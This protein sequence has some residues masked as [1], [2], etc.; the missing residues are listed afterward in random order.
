VSQALSPLDEPL[1][2]G[3]WQ[4]LP[5]PMISRYLA[6]MKW[7]WVVLD[8]QHGPMSFETA[9]ECVQ[10]L[11]AG[12]T[13]PLVRVAINTPFEVQ[14][15]LDIG[16]AGVVVP[17]TNTLDMAR[18]LAAAAKYPPR[19]ERSL[20]GDASLLQGEDYPERAN[21][22][23][24]LLVQ[25]EHAAAVAVVDGMMAI[26]GVDGCFVGPTDLALSMGLPRQGYDDDPGHRAAMRRIVEACARH[27]KW[28]CCN[29]Y[30]VEDFAAKVR[31]G[32]RAITLRSEVDLL[33]A[34]GRNL[35]RQLRQ[36]VPSAP[37]A[38]GGG[39]GP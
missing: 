27:G 22:E 20:G 31:D 34:G 17:M 25:V 38:V 9:Y 3:I 18:A 36:H 32:F 24:L 35:L 37:K 33:M 12:G 5:L 30:D 15:A 2:V 7:D 13:T 23:T 16:A 29:T 21:G 28:P 10:T 26:D 8:L 14:R 1:R 39:S 6:A 19:G 11:R 4:S